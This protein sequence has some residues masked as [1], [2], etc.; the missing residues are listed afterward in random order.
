MK[1]SETLLK[2]MRVNDNQ[3]KLV[4]MHEKQ[5][6]SMKN[7]EHTEI[8]TKRKSTNIIENKLKSMQID[9][10]L[11]HMKINVVGLERVSEC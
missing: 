1:S 3:R 5:R 11:W 8:W 7:T 9:E 4:N 6:K 10:H 2:A